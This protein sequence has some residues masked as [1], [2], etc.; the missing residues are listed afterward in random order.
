MHRLSPALL[1]LALF[2]HLAAAATTTTLHHTYDTPLA[3]PLGW[4]QT[5][6][7]APPAATIHLHF[8]LKQSNVSELLTRLEQVSE[9]SSPLYGQ[10]MTNHQ[11]QQL[12][13]PS[14]TALSTVHHYLGGQHHTQAA[15]SNSDIIRFTTTI[16]EAET[17]LSCK[18]YEYVHQPTKRTAFRTPTYSLPLFVAAHVAAVT[19]TVS[20]HTVPTAKPVKPVKPVKQRHTAAPGHPEELVNIPSTLRT[21]YGVNQTQGTTGQTKMAVTG[22]I[23]QLYSTSDYS[24]FQT[25]FLNATQMGYNV[26]TSQLTCK[27]DDGSPSFLGGTE[28]ML[29]AEYITALGSNIR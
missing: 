5:K 29:D 4:V 15:T 10:H 19:P 12:T 22:F 28:A 14:T 13:A 27:G 17:L 21:L 2:C 1:S 16:A 6:T 25:Q 23:Q 20:L 11:V 9:P 18:Y 3:H 8:L 7:R 26:S 24:E